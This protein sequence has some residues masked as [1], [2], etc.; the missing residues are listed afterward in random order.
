M[1]DSPTSARR[2]SATMGTATT[3]MAEAVQVYW[4]T[5]ISAPLTFSTF[6][7]TR[8]EERSMSLPTPLLMDTSTSVK[9][10]MM[11]IRLMEMGEILTIKSSLD[12]YEKNTIRIQEITVRSEE[13]EFSIRERNEIREIGIL[14]IMDEM[15]LH[16]SLPAWTTIDICRTITLLLISEFKLLEETV[17]LSQERCEMMATQ[18]VMMAELQDEMVLNGV[19]E[20]M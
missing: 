2:S 12:L 10:E 17:T 20:L 15:D 3:V 7:V 6:K 13:T 5:G 1:E 9:S 11:Q 18:T 4:R 16:D 19:D 14:I 8:V